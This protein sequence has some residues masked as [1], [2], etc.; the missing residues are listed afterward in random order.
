MIP[1]GVW[2]ALLGLYVLYRGREVVRAK[3]P[4][5]AGLHG[6]ALEARSGAQL[7]STRRWRWLTWVCFGPR[8][9]EHVECTYE[10]AMACILSE[11]WGD[12]ESALLQCVRRG[13]A[14]VDNWPLIARSLEE[15]ARCRAHVADIDGAERYL[16]RAESI[17]SNHLPQ[18]AGRH[19][20]LLEMRA[21]IARI[22]GDY[23]LAETLLRTLRRV[24]EES[25][26]IPTPPQEGVGEWPFPETL[27]DIDAS[28]ARVLYLQGKSEAAGAFDADAIERARED[29]GADE[30]RRFL[31][32]VAAR[33]Y[34]D[35]FHSGAALFYERLLEVSSE[36]TDPSHDLVA[37][38]LASAR[39]PA[40]A[41]ELTEIG[42]EEHP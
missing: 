33:R 12:A 35:G 22:S 26:D 16:D 4:T 21:R 3:Y 18:R 11:R 6:D 41:R 31:Q 42:G 38:W 13:H 1:I 23:K 14:R 19:K 24:L 25:S 10:Y 40:S 37:A 2:S 34:A 32:R 30:F 39:A 9:A 20:D 29:R 28:L 36:A 15:L 5:A 7:G 17:R 27:A 8:S